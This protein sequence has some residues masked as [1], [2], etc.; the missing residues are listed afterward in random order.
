VLTFHIKSLTKN[1]DAKMIVPVVTRMQKKHF[2][3][4]FDCLFV[5]VVLVTLLRTNQ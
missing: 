4:R 1:K 2:G 5:I 3:G